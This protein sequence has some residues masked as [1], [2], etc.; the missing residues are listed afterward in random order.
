[1]G[2]RKSPQQLARFVS[3]VLGRSP[4]E[5]G[6]VLHP[7]GF[8]K[9]REFLK[10]IHEEE[11]WKYV[12]RSH[13]EEIIISLPNPPIEIHGDDI[14][15]TCRDHLPEYIQAANLPRL[16]FT[17][18]RRKAYPFV[19]ERGIFPGPYPYVI[20]SSIKGMAERLGKRID[21]QPVALT[22]HTCQAVAEGVIFYE[23]GEALYQTASLPVGCFAGPLLPKRKTDATPRQH[24]EDPRRQIHPGSFLID[25]EGP[26]EGKKL[27]SHRKKAQRTD[28]KKETKKIK[29][30][31][32]EP[33]P[34]RT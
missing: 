14:R 31:R 30:G 34:W 6:L 15:A 24:F 2:Q 8:V 32:R 7:D 26:S 11:G 23:A 9:L 12:Q 18:V 16:L 5:F 33:P 25:L 10:A 28:T 3:Y 20:L 27:I 22:V 29:K 17:C 19:L 21:P 4:D 13:I 1:M